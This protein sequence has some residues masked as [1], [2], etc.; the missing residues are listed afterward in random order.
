MT[1]EYIFRL[2]TLTSSMESYPGVLNE[3]DFTD[4]ELSE[5]SDNMKLNNYVE[6][7][8]SLKVAGRR[9]VVARIPLRK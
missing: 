3:Y 7:I 9:I 4:V 8:Q 2:N 6:K 1:S 5:L